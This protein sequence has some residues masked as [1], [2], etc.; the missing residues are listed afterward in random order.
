M[1]TCKLARLTALC[2]GFCVETCRIIY[3]IC[4]H[5]EP[6][7]SGD[8]VTYMFFV[9]VHLFHVGHPPMC[10]CM[11][12]RWWWSRSCQAVTF[13]PSRKRLALALP[14]LVFGFPPER[15]ES[16]LGASFLSARMQYTKFGSSGS[17]VATSQYCQ[18]YSNQVLISYQSLAA[19]SWQK[20]RVMFVWH[21][22]ENGPSKPLCLA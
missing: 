19:I 7:D 18:Y 13:S 17:K 15:S 20:N 16:K 14:P 1:Y 11:S 6:Q 21:L 8:P 2:W 4:T 3:C 22:Q 9:G 5:T 12:V 10:L